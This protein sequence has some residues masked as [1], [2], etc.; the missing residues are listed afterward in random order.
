MCRR[1]AHNIDSIEPVV[2][3]VR[4]RAARSVMN[5]WSRRVSIIMRNAERRMRNFDHV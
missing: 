2:E 4:R 1:F 5:G 3:A